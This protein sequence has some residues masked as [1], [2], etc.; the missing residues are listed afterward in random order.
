[1]EQSQ[2]PGGLRALVEAGLVHHRAGRLEE[3]EQAYRQ[4][5]DAAP[6]HPDGLHYSGVLRHQKGDP[7]GAARLMEQAA[8]PLSG[9][10]DFHAN[11]GLALSASGHREKAKAQ[12]RMALAA[13]PRQGA[14]LFNLGTLLAEDG[15]WEGAARLFRRLAE[16]SPRAAEP[17]ESL[18]DALARLG[19]MPE[20]IEQLREAISLGPA[21]VKTRLRLAEILA[22]TGDPAAA[23]AAIEGALAQAPGDLQALVGMAEIRGQRGDAAG[24]ESW[25]AKARA[26]HPNAARLYYERAR[27][28]L[29][30]G[31]VEA[32]FADLGRCLA[33]DPQFALAE[34][35]YRR[36]LPVVYESD[37]E[38]EDWRRRFAEGL[39]ILERDTRL[40]SP[41]AAARAFVSMVA[42][43]N[44][45][46]AYQERDDRA[47]QT[48]FGRLAA[49]VM[50]ARFPEFAGDLPMP[51]PEP[52][53][54]LRI[55]F[56]SA[57]FRQHTIARLYAGWFE[58]LDRRRFKIFG[59]HSS[60]ASDRVTDLIAGQCD[61]FRRLGENFAAKSPDRFVEQFAEGCRAVAAD[62]PHVLIFPDVGMDPKSFCV[63]A[64]RLARVQAVGI[65]HPVTTG[66]PT[67]DYFLSGGMIEP[68]GAES[69]YS[70][71]LVRLPNI[72][73]RLFDSG[74][75]PATRSKSRAAFDFKADEIVYL[76]PQSIFKYLPAYDRIFPAVAR[77]VPG[78]R[79]V[80]LRSPRPSWDR[81]FL[82]RLTRAFA[83]AGLEWEHYCRFFDRMAPG[84]YGDLNHAADVYLDTPGW[85]GGNTTHEAISAGLPVVTLPGPF[86]RGRV[87]HGMLRMIGVEDTVARD[88]DDYIAIAIRLGSDEAFRRAVRARIEANRGKLYNDEACVRGLEEFLVR[89]VADKTAKS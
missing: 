37:R 2:D 4:V 28:A 68:E 57:C 53:G 44:F 45:Y 66:L 81:P 20:A 27:S 75:A 65:G 71:T 18:G 38:I 24:R 83:A 41:N 22:Q 85:S 16:I 12:M 23:E 10:A 17:R 82:V 86:M 14:A 46:L 36:L 25:L 42:T 89:A 52:D 59:Y 31:N 60:T 29:E 84:E 30:V 78:A 50:A 13:N 11:Y 48:R 3:A 9:Q 8:G 61:V 7:A 43:T 49:R 19:R 79:F 35:K 21:Q 67:M 56:F 39:A 88:E 34:W 58:K 33:L 40:D 6:H 26:A 70:E 73:L 69:H 77:A 76:S 63:A 74:G 51:E 5:L 1:M 72:S 62:R 15:D 54:R 32:E 80:F 87:S 64:L 55:G 47:L